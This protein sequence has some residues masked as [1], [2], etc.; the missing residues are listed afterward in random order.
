MASSVSESG[1]KVHPETPFPIGVEYY[2]A[3]TPR[4]EV[5]DEDFARIKAAGLRIVRS[6]S[7]WNWMEPR[8]GH[9]ELDDFDR[10]F[11]LA[12]KHGLFV[13]LD[14]TLATHGCCPD[15]LTREHPDICAVDRFGKPTDI[16]G[17]AAYPHGGMRHCYDHP[18][19]RQYGGGLLRHVVQRYRDRP[20]LLLW[21]LWDGISPIGTTDGFPCYCKNSLARYKE[22]LKAQFSLDE[23]NQRFLRRYQ[24]WEEVEPPRYN[25]NVVEMLMF[26]RFNY[27]NLVDKLRWMVDETR[28]IDPHHELRIHG[29][30]I[31]GPWDEMCAREADSW[32]MSMPSNNLLTPKSPDKVVQRAF[33]FDWSR[34]I[35]SQGRWWNE[36]IYA[37]MSRAG[38]TWKKQTDPRELTMLVWMSLAGGAA[39]AMFWQYRPEYLSFEAPGYNLTALDGQPTA[40]LEAASDVIAKIDGM[41]EHLPLEFPRADIG[42]VYH[43]ISHELFCFNND[44]V[45]YNGDLLG[46]YRT[47]WKSGIPADLLTPRMDW[48][49]YRLI[50]LPN[51]AL[52][53]DVT[54][55]RIARTL[56]ESPETR[57]IF[58]GSFGMYSADGQSSYCPPEGFAERLGVRV[59]DFSALT[60]HDIE[61]GQNVLETPYGKVAITSP[62]GYAV[63]DP[64]G[65]TEAILQ[66]GDETLGVRSADGRFTWFGLTL[67]AGFGDVGV[68]NIVHGLAAEAGIE[69]PIAVDG[70]RAVPV[71]RRSRQGGWLVFVFNIERTEACVKLRPSWRTGRVND[72]LSG[73]EVAVDDNQFELRIAPWEVAVVHC[74]ELE[75]TSI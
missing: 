71:A 50:F 34:A 10:L 22:W 43:A 68:A 19:W 69:P 58:E 48:S 53:D 45:R 66:L 9:Y 24:S 52:M 44:S 33:I 14:I 67:S 8:P 27:E 3:P 36:E 74:A 41:G 65:D 64:L 15:W 49:G 72:L 23:L 54:R 13:W 56:E 12:E 18:A 75:S 16:H 26:R 17:H 25:D 59:A 46:V 40:R 60:E 39:G 51:V 57:L 30:D 1:F 73:A 62:C 6:F 4:Q 55:E 35:G 20:N 7:Y 47:L 29:V 32:G 31:P 38:T 61:Q 11:D 70:D 2:R 28:Q 21:G 37:G 5:W 63:L 42:I